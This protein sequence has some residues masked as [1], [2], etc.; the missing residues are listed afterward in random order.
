M[1]TETLD[2][3]MTINENVFYALLREQGTVHVDVA[4]VNR[5]YVP[6]VYF[7]QPGG[8]QRIPKGVIMRREYLLGAET[9]GGLLRVM[10]DITGKISPWTMH[11]PGSTTN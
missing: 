10:Q 3:M 8:K 11:R 2:A 7:T 6:Y 1:T 4:L 9:R 5:Y